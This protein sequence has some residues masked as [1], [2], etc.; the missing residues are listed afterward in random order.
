MSCCFKATNFLI[1]HGFLSKIKRITSWPF[2]QF[3]IFG[4]L[5]NSLRSGNYDVYVCLLFYSLTSFS[6]SILLPQVIKSVQSN[7]N[8]HC[9]STSKANFSQKYLDL[10]FID[11]NGGYR[12][13]NSSSF[14]ANQWIIGQQN[15]GKLHG[16]K[17]NILCRNWK[18]EIW[19][20]PLCSYDSKLPQEFQWVWKWLDDCG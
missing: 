8:F 6:H 20:I 18:S 3:S 2:H 15:L 4:T 17:F 19:K 11:N 13:Q 16:S 14:G 12:S 1:Y 5:W 9:G 10:L 7:F